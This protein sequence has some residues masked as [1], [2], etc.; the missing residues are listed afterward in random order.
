MNRAGR[1]TSGFPSPLLLVPRSVNDD[2]KSK[3]DGLSATR[4]LDL[5]SLIAQFVIIT[6]WLVQLAVLRPN[7]QYMEWSGRNLADPARLSEE[8]EGMV[9]SEDEMRRRPPHHFI[10]NRGD[11]SGTGL[12]VTRTSCQPLIFPQIAKSDGIFWD[13]YVDGSP[14]SAECARVGPGLPPDQETKIPL[15]DHRNP[16]T[17]DTSHS[18]NL[19]GRMI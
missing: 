18:A 7:G 4:P 11:L 19:S 3:T 1:R 10:G 16:S 5:C 15:V 9:V 13:G 17:V 2:E 12:G 6:R 8:P 14:Y